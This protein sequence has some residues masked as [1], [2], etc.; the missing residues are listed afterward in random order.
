MDESQSPGTI[1]VGGTA[2]FP[3]SLAASDASQL[4]ISLTIDARTGRIAGMTTT[5]TEGKYEE[6][7]RLMLVGRQIDEVGRIVR[8][9]RTTLGG[10]LL[11]PTIEALA[12]AVT[13]GKAVLHPEELPEHD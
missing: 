2:R 8:E 4:E 13:K 9:L 7:L 11:K 5:I 10:R 1:T 6:L 3:A 12:S